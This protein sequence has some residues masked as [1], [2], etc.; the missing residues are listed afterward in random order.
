MTNEHVQLANVEKAHDPGDIHFNSLCC[1][2]EQLT[3]DLAEFDVRRDTCG[4][5]GRPQN[6]CLCPHMPAEIVLRKNVKIWVF[7][8]PNEVRFLITQSEF[9]LFFG[10]PMHYFC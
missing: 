3:D 6:V 4:E 8:H 7:Q 5:C 2:V 9:Q 10:N 1:M